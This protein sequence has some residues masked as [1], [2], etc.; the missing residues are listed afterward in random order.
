MGEF[1]NNLI[2]I[3]EPSVL[4]LDDKIKELNVKQETLCEINKMLDFVGD[5]IGRVG[6]Y[7]NQKLILD[8]L[9][10]VNSNEIEYKASCYLLSSEDDKVKLLPQYLDASNYIEKIVN[11]F[12]KRQEELTSDVSALEITCNNKKIDKKYL[13]IFRKEN[14]LIEDVEEFSDFLTKKELINKDKIDLI[15]YTINNNVKN[16]LQEERVKGR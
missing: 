7:D 9:S 15:V 4:D 8:Y 10:D 14:P 5:D 6:K 16:Y 3:L 1:I 2:S 12:K 11:L 13:D